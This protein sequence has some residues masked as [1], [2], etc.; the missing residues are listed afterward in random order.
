MARDEAR[1]HVGEEIVDVLN[2]LLAVA[3]RLDIDVE[4]AFRDKNAR[5]PLSNRNT[6][7]FVTAQ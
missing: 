3:N 6:T 5:R 1:A 2:Y 4:Q 7:W